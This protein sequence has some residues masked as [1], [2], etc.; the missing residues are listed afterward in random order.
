[1]AEGQE[2]FRAMVDAEKG[3]REAE[4]LRRDWRARK[5]RVFACIEYGI[6]S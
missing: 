2:R 3:K 6:C 5:S 4:I 1:M